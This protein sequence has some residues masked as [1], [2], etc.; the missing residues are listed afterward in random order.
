MWGLKTLHIVV[1][2]KKREIVYEDV[3]KIGK[4]LFFTEALTQYIK[5]E[6]V[7]TFTCHQIIHVLFS[8]LSIKSSILSL[9]FN[10]F[11]TCT[12]DIIESI[13]DLITTSMAAFEKEHV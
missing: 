9:S 1:K 8:H 10:S 2:K 4:V 3:L 11:K 13:V 5:S 12:T 6:V 7:E